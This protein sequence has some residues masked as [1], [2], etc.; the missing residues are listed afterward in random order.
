MT[1]QF[2]RKTILS[3]GVTVLS[4]AMPG[5]KS[6]AL[7]VWMRV[8][9]RDEAANEAGLSHFLEHM[10][11][12]GTEKRSAFEISEA[13][14]AMGAEF[15]AFTTKET[16]CY[17]A[18]L[19]GQKIE[20]A[21]D[22]LSDMVIHSSFDE[23]D[24]VL[25]REVVLEEIARANDTPDDL[26]FEMFSEALLPKHPLGKPVLGSKDIIQNANHEMARA[27]HAKH[28]T[29]ENTVVAAAGDVNHD[30]LV[31]MCEK[32]FSDMP[33][34][35]KLIRPKTALVTPKLKVSTQKDTEQTQLCYGF[36]SIDK[37]HPQRYVGGVLDALLGGGMSSR[38]FQ[39][40]REKRGLVYSISSFTQSF[41]DLGKFVVYAASRPENIDE[42]IS[43]I[44]AELEKICEKPAL[45]SE[46]NRVIEYIIGLLTLRL[47]S[48][49]SRMMKLGAQEVSGL[50]HI[51][52]EETL[53]RYREV[54]AEK[55]LEFAQEFY[56][57]TPSIALVEPKA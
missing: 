52:Y 36:L 49:S 21:L 55:I 39:E 7:G 27:Y 24:I 45:D 18:R 17:Y 14:E 2:Y 11:F 4:E 46:V 33:Q 38:L 42:I 28:Y 54:N 34:G 50:E 31:A 25:E 37:N 56:T 47:E 16:T 9:S 43:I 6:A 57:Q 32:Y 15:N 48:T 12:K 30:E 41:T 19:A 44:D 1:E 22:I 26:V 23:D 5:V 3:N 20:L 8:G 13:F 29:S 51:S 53:R 40:V 35:E 10:M